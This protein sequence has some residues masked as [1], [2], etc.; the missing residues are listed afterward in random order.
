[1]S[2]KRCDFYIVIYQ[3]KNKYENAPTIIVQLYIY[4]KNLAHTTLTYMTHDGCPIMLK[5]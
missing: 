5:H 3:C 4:F 1:M 2:K